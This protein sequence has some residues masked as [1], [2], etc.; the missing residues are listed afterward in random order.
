ENVY[1]PA[2][3]EKIRRITTEIE[4]IKGVQSVASLTNAPDPIAD[5]V[6]PPLLVP[7]I[8][9][10]PAALEALRHKVEENPV[11]LNLVSRDGKGAAVLIFLKIPSEDELL[12]KQV[13]EHLQEIVKREQGPEQLYLTGMQNIK[14]NSLKMMKEDLR[15]FTPLSLV[16]IM[17][18]LGFCFR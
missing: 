1:T 14:V 7:Q 4:K 11:Y 17:G 15:T 10:D 12:G 18:V 16:V 6:D 2:T 8:P 13:D 3:L 9:T 5:V